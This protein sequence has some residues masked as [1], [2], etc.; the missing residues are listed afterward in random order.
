M[1][2]ELGEGAFQR[3]KPQKVVAAVSSTWQAVGSRRQLVGRFVLV[4]PQ[5]VSTP[6]HARA[7]TFDFSDDPAR[8]TT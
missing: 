6:L 5:R 7:A 2:C 3:Q 1:I 4:A 8:Q